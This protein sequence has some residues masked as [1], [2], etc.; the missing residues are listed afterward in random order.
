M[1]DSDDSNVQEGED[2]ARA[3]PR[4]ERSTRAVRMA[5]AELLPDVSWRELTVQQILDRAGVSRGTFYA[6]YRGKDDALRASMGGML[7][8]L[9]RSPAVGDRLFPVRELMDHVASATALQHSLDSADR[10][11]QLWEELR[12]ELARRLADRLAPM[13]GSSPEAPVVAG[14]VLAGAMVELTRYVAAAP[15]P[16]ATGTLDARFHRMAA[17]TIAAFGCVRREG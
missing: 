16:L 10:L 8:A 17:T 3:D 2:K 15:A 11:G 6:H 7:S 12:E 13:P 5:L 1:M 14:R 9:Q 4:V